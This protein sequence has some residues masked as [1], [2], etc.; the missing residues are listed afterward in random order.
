MGEV[1]TFVFVVLRQILLF[2][3]GFPTSPKKNQTTKIAAILPGKKERKPQDEKKNCLKAS[4]NTMAQVV[5][6]ATGANVTV[7]PLEL[8]LPPGILC[9]S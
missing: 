4:K 2:K 1:A 5:D 8:E 7:F 6:F 9:K 3:K